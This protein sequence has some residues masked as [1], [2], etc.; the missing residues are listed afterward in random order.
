MQCGGLI[1]AGRL[2]EEALSPGERAAQRY[3]EDD[4]VHEPS[5]MPL[6]AIGAALAVNDLLLMVTGLLRTDSGVRPLLYDAQERT[7]QTVN[8]VPQ[9]DCRYCGTRD[10]SHFARGDRG[11]LP[12]RQA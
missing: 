6:N 10:A 9:P 12:C 7:L 4:E 2:R 3:V 5:V 11:R 1:P 8:L